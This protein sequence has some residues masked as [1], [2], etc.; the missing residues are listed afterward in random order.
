M[1]EMRK[2]MNLVESI[3]RGESYK[4]NGITV[5]DIEDFVDNDVEEQIEEAPEDEMLGAVTAPF[6][7]Q[8]LQDYLQRIK[9]KEKSKSDKFGK[10]YIHGSNIEI[11]DDKSGKK[12]DTD[13]LMALVKERPKVIL[14]QNQKMQHKRLKKW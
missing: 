12:F 8:E 11:V 4:I 9:D 14:K 7:G 13:K 5:V 10:P 1:S 3:E 6:K 2:L